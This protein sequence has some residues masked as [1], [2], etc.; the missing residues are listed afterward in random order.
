MRDLPEAQSI[1]C[2]FFVF[3]SIGVLAAV[4]PCRA[5]E[6]PGIVA[7]T[8]TE[9][10]SSRVH[11]WTDSRVKG[12]P[13]PPL[14]YT[15]NPVFTRVELDRP[16]DITWLP[17][18]QKWVANHAGNK[19][20][21]FT[22]DIQTAVAQP[23]LN[24]SELSDEP[25]QT[26]YAT[27]FHFDL[28]NQ[29]WCFLT[30]TTKRQLPDGH[31]LARVKVLDPSVPTFDLESLTE[32][33]RWKSHGH[34]GSSMQFGPDGMLYVSVG[35]GQPPYP[36][37]GDGTGQ[38]LSDLRAS[39]LRIDVDDPTADKP[40]RVPTDNPFVHQEGAR[41]EIWAYGFRNPWK[42]AFAPNSEELLVADVGWEMREMIHRVRRGRNHGWSIMEG[43]Q[44]VKPDEQPEV[45]ITPPLFEHTH[46][47]SRSITGGY[48]WQSDRIP[49]L[50][51]AY[52]YGDWMT[53]K[54]W[55][56]RFKDDK[57][58]WQQ[59]LV[60][61]PHRVICFML[62]P[63]GEVF[64][65]GYDGTIL[66]LQPNTVLPSD[67]PFPTK[68]SE[69][70]IFAD[71]PL[72]QPA[73]GV[74]QYKINAHRWADGTHSRQWIALPDSSQLQLFKRFNWMTGESAGR[75][76]F[77][78]D[79]VAVKTVSYYA[80]AQNPQSEQHLETQLLHK[81]GDEWRAY[82][83]IWNDQ[84]TDAILQDDKATERKLIIKD[85]TADGGQRTQLWRHASRSECLLCHIWSAGT[86]QGFW[87][88]QLDLNLG[89]ENQLDQLA[90]LGLF[91]E[92]VPRPE[93]V[94]SPSDAAASLEDRARSYLAMN[95]STCHRNLGGGTSIFTFD[96]T[97]PLEDSKYLDAFPSQGSFGIEDARVIA[98]GDPSRSVL[99]YRLLKSGRGH[100]PQFGSNVID[101]DGI[102]LIHDW[103]ASM[104]APS[105]EIKS[106]P[107]GVKSLDLNNVSESTIQSML[108]T[109]EGAM[110]LSM[111]CGSDSL[112][113]ERKEKI[114]G[115]GARHPHAPIRDLF[116]HYLPEDQRTKRL[117]PSVDEEALLA[118]EGSVESGMKLFET[119]TDV[120]CRNCH[121]IG[122]VGQNIGPDLSGI[123]TQQTPAEL[124]GS[125][126]RPSEKIDPKYRAKQIL[127]VDGE[128]VSGIVLE[129]TRESIQIAD[130]SGKVHK[131]AADDIEL[132]RF[133]SKS[134]MPDQL[135][136]GMTPQNA[137]DLL[138][139]LSSQRKIGPLQHKQAMV[140]RTSAKMRID[141]KRDETD[142]ATAPSLGDFVFTWW[143][144]GDP[145]KQQTDAK[146]LWDDQ[147]LYVSYACVDQ[148]VRATR[149]GRDSKVYRDDCV[150]IFASPELEHPENYFNI[151]MN[152]LG[153]QL[154]QYRP[155][156]EMQD[157]WNPDGIQIAVTI[158]GTLNDSNDSDRGWTLEAAIPFKL[159]KKVLP[160]GRPVIG[161]RWRLNL[162]R[163]EDEMAIKSQ[164]SQG[165][166]NFPRFHHPEYFGFVEFVGKA[167][168]SELP[169]Q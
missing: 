102:R 5:A 57:V 142:W 89:D 164:W 133:A 74:A 76:N 153:E 14:P 90:S 98:P 43:S 116:E 49:E 87:P 71:T 36:P 3:L 149:R 50:K 24:L 146:L 70:G 68:L 123:G 166:R 31:C 137:A 158:D 156:G 143:K 110:I 109:V 96:I 155:G 147:F 22:N 46:L 129:E 81:N 60:D 157:N 134:A 21:T 151:E 115:M 125:I 6:R 122:A 56:L 132:L 111:A 64:I 1:M 80:D 107:P 44:P 17:T 106:L 48:F 135:L 126:V 130:A 93:P 82:N 128:A 148:D 7:T 103:I 131:I 45:P 154:D 114:V 100:M 159:F 30:F 40:Y 108:S 61:T 15:T 20:V 27:K 51:G 34:V 141:G 62:D 66:Q 101:R 32:L 41:G 161:D 91:S 119:A 72:Q 84:Q 145:P 79:T 150:E 73:Q 35:D 25:V 136:S 42:M 75:F 69:T 10:A 26:G 83:Y 112:D 78:S 29:P 54:V 65:V 11:P 117:G 63:S 2:R 124:L 55:G 77:P 86:V 167:D 138:A 9:T 105:N 120:N 12:S 169:S 47:D 121:R 140:H 99:M 168:A 33:A 160:N 18:A 152:A 52:I 162:S 104:E 127:T 8:A 95:C 4:T 97:V 165:D 85:L 118:I 67:E 13:D 16:T 92:P 94:V 139:Y 39:I 28:E 113:D 38:D 23:L 163:L 53:G 88:P 144:D 37:D 58:T 59:E 19:I